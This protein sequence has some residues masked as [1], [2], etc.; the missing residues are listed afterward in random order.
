MA[1]VTDDTISCY[2]GIGHRIAVE[3]K[4]QGLSQERLAARA[5]IARETV[6]KIENGTRLPGVRA[7]G[8]ISRAL[9]LNVHFLVF[10]EMRW[11]RPE[12]IRGRT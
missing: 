3:R 1:P 2:D 4:A 5:G 11:L 6:R 12:V 10:G 9:N 8:G 7:L